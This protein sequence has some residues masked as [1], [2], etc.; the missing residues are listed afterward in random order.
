MSQVKNETGPGPANGWTEPAGPGPGLG[1]IAWTWPGPDLGQSRYFTVY[2]VACL[3]R[4][5][6]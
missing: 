2:D 1:K 5:L 3:F 4:V 6:V